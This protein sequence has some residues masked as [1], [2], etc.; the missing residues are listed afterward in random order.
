MQGVLS[1]ERSARSYTRYR[2]VVLVASCFVNLCI[3]SLYAWS[4]FAAPMGA[5]LSALAGADVGSLAVVFTVA[6]AVGPVTMISG[7]LVNDR[8]GPRWVILAGGVLF[9]AG[10][11]AS[12]FAESVPMLVVAY[13][14]GCGLGMGMVYGATVSNAVKFFPDKGG[15]AGGVATASYGMSSVIVPVVA[16]ALISSFDV[17]AAFK[18]L[19]VA[20]LVVICAASLFI[21][22]CPKGFVPDGWT[23][24]REAGRSLPAGKDWRGMLKD[25]VFYLMLA[26]LCCGA[27]SGLMVTSQASLIAQDVVGMGAGQAALVVSVLA[28]ANTLGRVAS[29]FASDRLGVGR[30]LCG[31]FALLVVGMAALFASGPGAVALF[32]AGICVVGF[33][34]GSVMGVYP[35][36]TASQFGSKNNSVNY[37][38][39][40]IGFALA[41]F[42]GPT[43]MSGLL[44]ALGSYQPAFAVAALLGAA[45]LGLTLLFG[46]RVGRK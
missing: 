41:G 23:P 10:M 24:P 30:T 9:G 8:L 27:F 34:F 39:M 12:G 32:C 33:C 29:G 7:G 35:G 14:L 11:I 16:N 15:L 45:G 42:L 37:G 20:M 18:I 25:P 1:R 44:G 17:V 36:F 4:V 13:G 19:G 3:G 38:I 5:H 2:W 43:I 46:R 26:M 40:F 22:A 28:L 21:E 6:N 31:V